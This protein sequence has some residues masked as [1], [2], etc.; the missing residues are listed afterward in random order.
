MGENK[1]LRNLSTELI[2]QIEQAAVSAARD[3][4][5]G[6][7]ISD[8]ERPYGIGLTSRLKRR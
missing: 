3:V 5:S 6:R 7:R 1:S 4:I 8:V 2:K